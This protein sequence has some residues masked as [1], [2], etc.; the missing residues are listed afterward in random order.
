MSN[1]TS[2]SPKLN[3]AKAKM[4][5]LH[6]EGKWPPVGHPLR[7][8]ALMEPQEV[9]QFFR[10]EIWSALLQAYQILRDN[11]IQTALRSPNLSTRDEARGVA[12][13]FSDMM[14]WA[15]EVRAFHVAIKEEEPK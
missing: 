5:Q 12:N 7:A 6:R 4:R 3:L 11:A 8:L 15:D 9:E 2:T 14:E 13:A 1:Q 10:G